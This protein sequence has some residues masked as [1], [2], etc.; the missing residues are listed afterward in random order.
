VNLYLRLL[1]LWLLGRRRSRVDVLG[2][3]RTPFRVWPTDLDLLRHVNNGTYLTIMD[4]GRLD[5]LARAGVTP[6]LRAKGWYPVVV[7]ETITFKRSLR[8]FQR[9]DIV[10]E[11][12]GWDDRSMYLQQDFF[13]GGT[14]VASGL[15]RGRFLGRDG[16]R[17]APQQ[18]LDLTG[19]HV[20]PPELPE[21][22][23][24]WAEATQISSAVAVPLVGTD[25]PVEHREVSAALR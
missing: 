18:V 7:A 17:I 15:I 8:L 22:V 21:W 2:P 13:C 1:H 23:P 19:R 3:V 5:L 11:V 24:A 20:E 25:L 4:I 10:T 16:S 9:F 14:L 12:V 6:L